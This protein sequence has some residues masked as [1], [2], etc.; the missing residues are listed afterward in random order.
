M[1]ARAEGDGWRSVVLPAALSVLIHG[2]ALGVLGLAM[3]GPSAGHGGRSTDGL[4]VALLGAE[5]AAAIPAHDACD[6][7]PAES[8]FS[9]AHE[10]LPASGEQAEALWQAMRDGAQALDPRAAA[11]EVTSSLEHQIGAWKDLGAL[12]TG[13]TARLATRA[14]GTMRGWS[15]SESDGPDQAPAHSSG[16][17]GGA[18][19]GDAEPGHGMYQAPAAW[20]GNAPP[21][22]PASWRRGGREGTVV[23]RMRVGVDGR[24]HHVTIEA[25]SGDRDLD[26]SAV[27]AAMA[28]RFDPA[29]LDGLPVEAEVLMP[30]RFMIRR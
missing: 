9:D 21:E 28:W 18:P 2:A 20:R 14:L 27:R 8:P 22:Y 26:E 11:W 15:E 16:H 23:L 13:A 17:A 29:R 4:A 3:G 24:A 7:P 12:A 19:A 5:P 1:R 25:G 10:S 30:V 6:T